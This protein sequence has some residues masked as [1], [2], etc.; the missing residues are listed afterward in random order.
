[1]RPGRKLRISNPSAKTFPLFLR[2]FLSLYS[3][4]PG[5]RDQEADESG[6]RNQ[7]ALE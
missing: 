2:T 6:F 4:R 5:K 3:E 7:K 1:M